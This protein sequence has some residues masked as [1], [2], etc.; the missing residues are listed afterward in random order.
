[1]E[2]KISEASRGGNQMADPRHYFYLD[3]SAELNGTAL[4]FAVKLKENPKWYQSDLGINYYR[5]D[6]SGYF[7]T[8]VRLPVDTRLDQIERISVRCDAAGNP[9]S[10]DEIRKLST[11]GCDLKTI[12]KGFML[13]ASFHPGRSLPVHIKPLKLRYGEA[14]EVF[15]RR[16]GSATKAPSH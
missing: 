4:S 15:A 9:R 7:R 11:A 5:I 2:G 1:R 10:G 8:T 12:N 3:A 16:G 14:I 6:R 13:D